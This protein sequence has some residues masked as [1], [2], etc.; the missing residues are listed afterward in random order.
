MTTRIGFPL[1]ALVW[2]LHAL[3][4]AAQSPNHPDTVALHEPGYGYV[5]PL[6][7]RAASSVLN[8]DGSVSPSAQ[9]PEQMRGFLEREIAWFDNHHA[10]SGADQYVDTGY[11]SSREYCAPRFFIGKG[12]V[13][14][15][16][17]EVYGSS[18]A[19]VLLLSEVV[20]TA[21]VSAVIPGF[22]SNG[23]PEILFALADVVPLH[24]R[25]PLPS[26]VTTP[27]SQFTIKGRVFCGERQ[28]K[29][30]VPKVGDRV[31]VIGHWNQGVVRV[32]HQLTGALALV[33]EADSSLTWRFM[34]VEDGPPTFPELQH[35]IAEAERGG[36]LD[37]AAPL[38][39]QEAYSPERR[40]FSQTW[41]EHH[42]NGCRVTAAERQTNG[43]WQLI[44]RCG[45]HERTIE[46]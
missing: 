25:S 14:R 10:E 38:L 21:T 43:Y 31:I 7:W 9:I 13:D 24:G 16:S 2:A 11:I 41:W 32:G 37:L 26:Y 40:Q 18:F 36:L 23:D 17:P 1:A 35:R 8:A 33:R 46:Q 5:A 15:G 27:V 42:Q 34:A 3:P 30:V 28:S 45:L 20:A 6:E 19:S 4:T 12:I 44:Q 39:V 29:E 22:L